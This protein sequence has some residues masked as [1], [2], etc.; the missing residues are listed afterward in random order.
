MQTYAEKYWGDCSKAI[1]Y[2]LNFEHIYLVCNESWAKS[3]RSSTKHDVH[4]DV[5][6]MPYKYPKSSISK[7]KD[8]Y[9]LNGYH[10]GVSKRLMQDM[11]DFGAN[12]EDFLPII[13]SR[14]SE[15]V[16][17]YS[18]LPKN[19]LPPIYHLNCMHKVYYCNECKIFKFE[20]N[21]DV[22]M[23]DA[24][25][26]SG[27]PVYID[28]EVLK[29]FNIINRTLEFETDVIINLE[30]YNYLINKYP[31]LE[32]RP[33]FIGNLADDPEYKRIHGI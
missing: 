28:E 23:L 20:Y 1:G 16:L 12:R 14:N 29:C 5:Q 13:N 21:D 6:V 25:N 4:F 17:G 18:L 22:N 33:V 2:Q 9:R 11:V 8:F 19:I 27:Y 15:D 24:Y 31:K 26:G 3:F 10:C 30:L 32:C 7:N